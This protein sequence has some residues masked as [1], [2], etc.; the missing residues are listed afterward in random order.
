MK[1][2]RCFPCQ[3]IMYIFL[4][5][6]SWS[7]RGT[8]HHSAFMG[9][10]MFLALPTQWMS[11]PTC[12]WSNITS[13]SIYDWCESGELGGRRTELFC[14]NN[15]WPK[16]VDGFCKKVHN[17]KNVKPAHSALS[18]TNSDLCSCAILP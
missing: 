1:Q 14:E 5:L 7:A 6:E 13:H 3:P 8:S 17:I 18:E 2:Y 15:Q 11:S 10:H 9:S 16:H 4:W 12:I